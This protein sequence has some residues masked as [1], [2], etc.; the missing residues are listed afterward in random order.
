MLPYQ[1]LPGSY[2]RRN[3]A[4][5]TLMKLLVL[6]SFMFLIEYVENQKTPTNVTFITLT[7]AG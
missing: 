1:S 2:P 5:K 4:N 3:R 6:I 7:F